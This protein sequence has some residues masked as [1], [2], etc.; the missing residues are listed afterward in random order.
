MIR[1]AS[2]NR[3]LA[4]CHVLEFRMTRKVA[5]LVVVFIWA[6]AAA[7]MVPWLV[8]F[9]LGEMTTP[10]QTIYICY[11]DWPSEALMKGFFLGVIVLTCYTL[12]LLLISVFYALVCFRV[13]HRDSLGTTSSEVIHRSKVKVLKMLI[14]VVSLFALSWLPLYAVNTRIYFG[15]A[16]VHDGLEFNI[17]QQVVIPLAQWLG[18]S[19]S[20]VNPIIYCLFCRKFRV[21]ARQLIYCIRWFKR[22]STSSGQCTYLAVPE[23]VT[24]QTTYTLTRRQDR[25]SSCDVGIQSNEMP[26]GQGQEPHQCFFLHSD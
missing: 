6:C 8:Y 24:L 14:V 3:Y 17:L 16:L 19:N 1:L 23:G 21:G 12:P 10:L 5:R 20:C 13:W 2:I 15:S 25:S 4:I 22:S 26:Q 11:Q 7:I 18:L 9:R